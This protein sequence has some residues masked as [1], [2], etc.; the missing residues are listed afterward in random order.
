MN[1]ERSS[2]EMFVAANTS[3]VTDTKTAQEIVSELKADQK[4]HRGHRRH[5]KTRKHG[6]LRHHHKHRRQHEHSSRI[7]PQPSW[8]PLSHASPTKKVDPFDLYAQVTPTAS[9]DSQLVSTPVI[10]YA[11]AYEAKEPKRIKIAQIGKSSLAT[12]PTSATTNKLGTSSSLQPTQ[13]TTGAPTTPGDPCALWENCALNQNTNVSRWIEELPNCPC[14]FHHP[15][16]PAYNSTIYDQKLDKY[17]DWKEIKVNKLIVAI[18]KSTADFCILQRRS[19]TIS[20]FAAQVCCYDSKKKLITRGVNAG[21]PFLVSPEW[22]IKAHFQF[23]VLPIRL[24]NGDWT[25]YHAV[26][27]PNNGLNCTENPDDGEF[28]RQVAKARDY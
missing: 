23:D 24:C 17:F 21:T 14:Q 5:H 27:P 22:S 19:F 6:K 18:L 2:K 7:H 15:K 28:A 12:T 1:E 4:Q 20:S 25:R 10:Q 13:T 8:I 26:R 11:R 9:F 3:K 16:Q